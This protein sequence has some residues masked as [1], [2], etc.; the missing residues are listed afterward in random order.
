VGLTKVG[1]AWG[2]YLNVGEVGLRRRKEKEKGSMRTGAQ[3]ISWT[4]SSVHWRIYRLLSI[5]WVERKKD[6]VIYS[7]S[8][9]RFCFNKFLLK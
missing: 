8:I 9:R 5:G 2:L 6:D 3:D 4:R 7:F 1:G